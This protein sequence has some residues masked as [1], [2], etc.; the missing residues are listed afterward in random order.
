[1]RSFPFA[2]AFKPSRI[3][4]VPLEVG[5]ALPEI[6]PLSF[7]E[8]LDRSF[9][10]YRSHFLALATIC[11][12][13]GL[14]V[15]P[16]NLL[17]R[18]PVGAVPDPRTLLRYFVWIYAYLFVYMFIQLSGDVRQRF[19]DFRNLPGP[20]RNRGRGLPQDVATRFW[21]VAEFMDQRRS[22]A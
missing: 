21:A 1:M 6:R 14:I 12:I 22:F 17:L 16:M 5:M 8:T 11:L 13:P 4:Q 2:I 9:A 7:G 3:A 19:R 15:S 18:M 20:R 10:F